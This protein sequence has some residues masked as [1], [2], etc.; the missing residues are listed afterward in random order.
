MSNEYTKDQIDEWLIQLEKK[1]I[2]P[3][4]QVPGEFGNI[5]LLMAVLKSNLRINDKFDRIKMFINNGCDVDEFSSSMTPLSMAAMGDPNQHFSKIVKYM[6]SFHKKNHIS[7]YNIL[8]AASKSFNSSMFRIVLQSEMVNTNN[9]RR[10][11][12]I[13]HYLSEHDGL[14]DHIDDIF[15]FAPETIPN[16][17]NRKGYSPLTLALN[18]ENK[19][20]IIYMSNNDAK[21]FGKLEKPQSIIDYELLDRYEGNFFEDFPDMAEYAVKSNKEYLLPKEAT[22]IF[23]F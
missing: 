11:S 7:D 23:L 1:E 4:H 9:S 2:K 14:G 22:D 13:L 3:D 16:P 5:P 18:N 21:I 8:T 10:K 15:T 12:H 17:I 20:A 6:L 19:N